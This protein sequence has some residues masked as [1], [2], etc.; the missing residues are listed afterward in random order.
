[1]EET[2]A[3]GGRSIRETAVYDLKDRNVKLKISI[4]AFESGVVSYN[5][6]EEFYEEQATLIRRLK[7]LIDLGDES[8]TWRTTLD[9][10]GLLVNISE[11]NLEE[12]S[13]KGFKEKEEAG[14]Q[15]VSTVKSIK[16]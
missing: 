11:N 12:F 16:K 14:G 7:H 8:H 2:N 3:K 4:K 9:L 1:M 10:I 13:D 6:F 15:Y 5:L